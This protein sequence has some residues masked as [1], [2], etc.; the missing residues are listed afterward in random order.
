[1][2]QKSVWTPRLATLL[3]GAG[4]DGQDERELARADPQDERQLVRDVHGARHR[5]A[6]S[7][8]PAAAHFS[9]LAG[10]QM[11]LLV[12]ALFVFTFI[13]MKTFKKKAT[14]GGVRYE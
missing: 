13:V 8:S 2:P 10:P 11:M 5:D 3:C 14:L 4:I 6:N 7:A 9:R 1:M 12:I